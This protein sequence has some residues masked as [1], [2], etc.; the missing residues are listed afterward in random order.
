ML[1]SILKRFL[2]YKNNKDTL[3][4]VLLFLVIYAEI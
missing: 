2:K 4:K 1:M 3:M